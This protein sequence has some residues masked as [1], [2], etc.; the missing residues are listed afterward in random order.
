MAWLADNGG[1]EASDA[2][3]NEVHWSNDAGTAEWSEDACV[4]MITITFT[5]ADTCGNE[6]T[7]MATFTIEDTTA[8]DITTEAG[9]AGSECQGTDQ[10]AN[11]DYMA[12]LADNGGAEES[13]I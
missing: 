10:D 8:P 3:G 6:R 4:R 9:N 7:T 11:T 5:A 1:A 2:C 13:N 12:W